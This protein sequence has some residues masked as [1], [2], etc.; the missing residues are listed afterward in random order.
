MIIFPPGLDVTQK[1]SAECAYN[2]LMLQLDLVED[3]S[4]RS[5]EMEH[6]LAEHRQ[7][8]NLWVCMF[9]EKIALGLHSS[10]AWQESALLNMQAIQ[11][12]LDIMVVLVGSIDPKEMMEGEFPERR[13]RSVALAQ[14][15]ENQRRMKNYFVNTVESFFCSLFL[16]VYRYNWPYVGKLAPED[17]ALV[18]LM[19]EGRRYIRSLEIKHTQMNN[20]KA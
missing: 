8:L 11:S 19:E 10:Q 15:F 5:L 14:S 20:A 13:T 12:T 6:M 7:Q 3:D 1:D 16:A 4:Q 9:M 17:V 2:R 18:S